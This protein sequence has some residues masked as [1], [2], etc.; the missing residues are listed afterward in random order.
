M[1]RT[2]EELFVK[3]FKQE[4]SNIGSKNIYSVPLPP[5]SANWR[6]SGTELYG[7]NGITKKYFSEL[8]KTI[9]RKVPR[10]YI[11][12]KRVVD[13]VIRGFK[14][15]DDGSYVYKDVTVPNGSMV[16]SSDTNIKLPY[17]EYIKE[18]K[19]GFSYVDFISNNNKKEYLYIVPKEN[20]Y[21]VHQTALAISVSSM[22]NYSG[23]GYKT[24]RSGI[25]Y[26]HIIPYNPNS[27]YVGSKILKT[28]C[29][30]NYDKEIE[31][32]LT[33]WQQ[34]GFIPMLALC[35]LESGENIAL[36]PTTVGYY[37]YDPIDKY[38]LSEK[39]QYGSQ[40]ESADESDL[41]MF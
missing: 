41:I 17:L 6:I 28:G 8:N 12:R 24:W 37:E 25:I 10:D 31:E 39:E 29:T 26:I 35:Q 1:A 19:D 30:L 11:V 40:L 4:I 36:K 5:S 7:V 14:T 13:K 23:S 3:E 34:V 22:K 15:N 2:L 33:Y 16:I 38:S 32:I 20:L 9:A 27:S 18:P 21:K